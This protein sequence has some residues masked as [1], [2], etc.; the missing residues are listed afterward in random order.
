MQ[1]VRLCVG[2]YWTAGDDDSER[3]R[4]YIEA[5][6]DVL[7]N[8]NSFKAHTVSRHLWFDNLLDAFQVRGKALAGTG[9][10]RRCS[11]FVARSQP[12]LDL[13]NAGFDLVEHE[14]HLLII[15]RVVPQPFRARAV[16]GAL[17]HGDDRG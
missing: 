5:L 12:G 1:A 3:R 2:E 9:S 15:E 6:G 17:Q 8:A 11:L 4:G 10:P 13:A 14:G 16:L 7:A